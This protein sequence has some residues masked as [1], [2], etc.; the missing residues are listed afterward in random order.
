MNRNLENSY[1]G[2]SSIE[3]DYI[4]SEESC[5]EQILDSH[6]ETN[7]ETNSETQ[8]S[9]VV[10]KDYL[11]TSD[12]STSDLSTSDILEN[13]L[14]NLKLDECI[15]CLEKNDLIKNFIC[16]CMFYYHPECYGQWVYQ[17]QIYKCIVCKC[18]INFMTNVRYKENIIA[19]LSYIEAAA[20]QSP[21]IANGADTVAA[22]RPPVPPNINPIE[23]FNCCDDILR[24][25]IYLIISIICGISS[26]VIIVL[27]LM[28]E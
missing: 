9:I 21:L 25:N 11:S 26:I 19:R 24:R 16:E 23:N 20:H 12:L 17:S 27:I 7:S 28:W 15:I 8:L 14:D 10:N 6:S 18:D 1:S 22:A 3:S 13:S 5:D 4:L 2:S